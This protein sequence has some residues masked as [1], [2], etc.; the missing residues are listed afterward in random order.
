MMRQRTLTSTTQ[1]LKR[2]RLS[3]AQLLCTESMP[4]DTWTA[5]GE[6]RRAAESPAAKDQHI[7]HTPQTT[8]SLSWWEPTGSMAQ[9]S[10]PPSPPRLQAQR[11][12]DL[13]PDTHSCNMRM[14][15]APVS[16]EM[17][18]D[19]SWVD[20]TRPKE[21]QNALHVACRFMDNLYEKAAT[22]TEGW[23]VS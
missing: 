12:S 1:T 9:H 7:F 19:T 2:Q 3:L 5:A 17:T 23:E 14:I 4:D 6:K 13:S 15:L 18:T 20:T 22:I 21:L 11:Q 10:E 8:F 16:D